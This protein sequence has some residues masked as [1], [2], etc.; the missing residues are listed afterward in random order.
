[1]TALT[2][3]QKAFKAYVLGQPSDMEHYIQQT[4]QLDAK[5]RLEIYANAYRT[6]LV[7]V[8]EKDYQTVQRIIGE[9]AF[10]ELAHGYV[11]AHPAES[12]TLRD[13]GSGFPEYLRAER[14]L[15]AGDLLY[16][17]AQL[18]RAFVEAFDGGTDRAATVADA[19]EIPI[20]AW[21][22]MRIRVHPS[23]QHLRLRDDAALHWQRLKEQDRVDDELEWRAP[24]PH[25]VWRKDMDVKFKRIDTLENELLALAGDGRTFEDL[26]ARAARSMPDDE[27]AGHAAGVLRSWLVAGLVSKLEW[28]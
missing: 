5:S 22:R 3:V 12:F 13:Y 16:D 25:V 11:E 6:R 10:T 26:C 8:L 20:S 2:A 27:A 23:L 7:A 18:E 17:L 28:K 14:A 19:S 4:P 24:V 9:Q 1:M 15:R 21:P